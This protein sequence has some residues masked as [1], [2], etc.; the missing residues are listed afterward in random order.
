[1]AARGDALDGDWLI[2]E[3][4]TAGRGRMGRRWESPPGNLYASGIVEL[5]GGDP[6]APTLALVAGVALIEALAVPELML[7]WPNDVV[8]SASFA[9]VAGILV[10]RRDDC[11]VAGFGVNLAHAP[12]LSDRATAYL[13][14]LGSIVSPQAFAHTLSEHWAARLCDWRADTRRIFATW[15]A[16]AHPVGTALAIDVGDIRI[17]GIFGGLTDQ[18]ALQLRLADGTVRVIHAGDVFLI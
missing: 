10:E 5:R 8:H 18:G 3:R 14:A 12:E 13:K 17:E 9:K 16:R 1:M 6:P 11:V 15:A 2:A 7:K 4:Q